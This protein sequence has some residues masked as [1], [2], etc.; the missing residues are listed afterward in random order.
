MA[1]AVRV[2]IIGAT[3]RGDYGHAIDTAFRDVEGAEIIGLSDTDRKAGKLAATRLGVKHHLFFENM[4]RNE[5]PDIVCICPRWVD[6]R[7]EM[8]EAAAGHG[9]HIYCEKPF[10]A[11]LETA[12]RIATV[13]KDEGVKL[14]MAHQ[15]RATAP[16]QQAIRDVRA[17]KYGKLLRMRARPKDDRRGGGEELLVHGT[18]LFDMML[19]FAGL[20]QWVCGHVTQDNA[21]ATRDDVGQ[22]TEP[23]GPI[24]GDSISAM[25]GFPN[26]V[27]GFFESTAGLS[28]AKDGRFR[29]VY[30]LTLECERALLSLR[31]PGDV[32][33]YPAPRVLP[34]LE[35]NWEKQWIE[36]WHFDAEH[37]PR[38]IRRTWLHIGNRFLA[39]D[40]IDAIRKKRN[41]VSPISH[42]MAITEIVQGVYAS[43]LAGG[44]RLEIPLKERGHPLV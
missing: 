36:D 26:G 4:L 29:E 2:A 12:D 33:V 17:G 32:F 8:I 3:G 7:L 41:P 37:K 9:C 16:V 20:P 40:L 15:W 30:G 1:D 14:Q 44:I 18:H 6:D 5:H 13:L 42:A 39:N 28:P 23:V 10:T 22:G 24:L 34:D 25:F 19:A 11:D 21:D 43:H 27:R 38:N 31:Q 35:L